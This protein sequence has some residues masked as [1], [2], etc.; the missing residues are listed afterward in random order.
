MPTAYEIAEPSVSTNPAAVRSAPTVSAMAASPARPRARPHI[1][2]VVGSSRSRSAA[3]TIVNGAWHRQ[4]I[5]S[6][7]A[8]A[9]PDEERVLLG[10][11]GETHAAEQRQV[12]TVRLLLL[13]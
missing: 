5:E 9:Q 3:R 1:W 13:P 11:G 12:A 10:R 4:W 7:F 6:G 8:G 2:R